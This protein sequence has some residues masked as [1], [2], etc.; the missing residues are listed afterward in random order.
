MH[1]QSLSL[2]RYY[3][4]FAGI[5]IVVSLAFIGAIALYE[6]WSGT[7]MPANAGVSLAVL[8]GSAYYVAHKFV[9]LEGRAPRGGEVL[10]LAGASTA[11]SVGW[12]L[13][14]LAGIVAV[15]FEGDLLY[16]LLLLQAEVPA[17]AW[18]FI[19]IVG[20]IGLMISFGLLC[21]IYGPAARKLAARREIR[22]SA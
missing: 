9:A 15:V 4:H 10:R 6:W 19:G 13:L 14:L 17:A 8:I 3:L 22:A 12:A 16:G 2:T 18:L 5:H 20:L 11:I 1:S 7:E 21:L